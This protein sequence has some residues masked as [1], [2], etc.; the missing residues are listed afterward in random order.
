MNV[1]Q[2]ARLSNESRQH[3]AELYR[4]DLKGIE[5]ERTQMIKGLD[6]Q[7]TNKQIS[8]EEYAQQRSIIENKSSHSRSNLEVST[9]SN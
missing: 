6:E 9:G 4:Q 1:D 7:L 3:N 2:V 5:T 8:Q